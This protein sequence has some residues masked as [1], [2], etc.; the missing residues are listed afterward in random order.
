[1]NVQKNV[2]VVNTKMMRK[3]LVINVITHVN[4]VLDL[5]IMNVLNVMKE[6]IYIIINV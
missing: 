6:L 2:H 3:I 4:V 1:M 5:K